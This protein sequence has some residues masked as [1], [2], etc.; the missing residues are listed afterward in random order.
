MYNIIHTCASICVF[1]RIY[2]LCAYFVRGEGKKFSASL[3]F[4]SPCAA[5][6]K[7]C[8]VLNN[9]F[10]RKFNINKKDKKSAE[11]KT[12]GGGGTHRL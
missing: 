3:G 12:D 2:M 4:K 8:T 11:K 10:F 5:A 6:I 7:T 9:R 1:I